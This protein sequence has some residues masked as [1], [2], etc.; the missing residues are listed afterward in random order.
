[1]CFPWWTKNQRLKPKCESQWSSKRIIADQFGEL[2]MILRMWFPK[3]SD[4]EWLSHLSKD[5]PG[6][7]RCFKIGL[8]GAP[9]LVSKSWVVQTAGVSKGCVSWK[10]DPLDQHRSTDQLVMSSINLLL[11]CCYQKGHAQST[12]L[13]GHWHWDVPI[14]GLAL[15]WTCRWTQKLAAGKTRWAGA[16]LNAFTCLFNTLYLS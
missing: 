9:Q 7:I 11:P 1:M 16:T 6:L 14:S 8:I 5:L 13:W 15:A 2:A 3:T 12:C 10:V 4:F